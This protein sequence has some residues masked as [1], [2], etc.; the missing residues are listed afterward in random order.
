MTFI[1]TVSLY[2]MQCSLIEVSY[3]MKLKAARTFESVVVT[4]QTT[5]RPIP[6]ICRYKIHQRHNL[7]FILVQRLKETSRVI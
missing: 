2:I 6:D 5:Q 4:F 1:T 3:T 7:Q